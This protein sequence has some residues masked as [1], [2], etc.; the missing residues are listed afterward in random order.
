MIL[1]IACQGFLMILVPQFDG[2]F[3]FLVVVI[4][5]YIIVKIGNN[6]H[7]DQEKQI[8]QEIKESRIQY[9]KT[10][11][12]IRRKAGCKDIHAWDIKNI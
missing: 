10:M 12:E 9:N 3:D 6:K 7:K 5:I 2:I 11:Q 4:A 8:E 1:K